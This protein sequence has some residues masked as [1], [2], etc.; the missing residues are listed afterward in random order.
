MGYQHSHTSTSTME[1]A[2]ITPCT[3]G[4]WY[5]HFASCFLTIIYYVLYCYFTLWYNS[6][7]FSPLFCKFHMKREIAGSWNSGPERGATEIA[8]L[9]TSKWPKNLWRIFLEYI[10]NIGLRNTR[11]GPT[12]RRQA[13]GRALPP[14]RPPPPELVAPLAGLQGPYS[15]I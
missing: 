12:R 8:I 9:H 7:A 5:V 6:Y 13:W 1:S 3:W 4:F 14:G 11:G 2:T 10:K 15:A